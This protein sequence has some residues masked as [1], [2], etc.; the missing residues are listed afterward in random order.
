MNAPARRWP[1]ATWRPVTYAPA[2]RVFS[3]PPLGWILH[4]TV[5]NGS[6]WSG[7]E[8]A[9]MG[10]RRF[11]HL[12]VAKD[13][14]AEQF[15]ELDH[16]SWAQGDGNDLYWSVETE[17]YPEE[18]LSLAQVETLARWHIWCGAD[19]ALANQPGW[20]GIGTHYMGGAAWGGHSCLPLDS[21]DVLTLT[22]WK[23]L[24][25]V[26]LSDRVA[27]WSVDSGTIEFAEPLAITPT[28]VADTVKAHWIEMTADHRVYQRQRLSGAY[29][30]VP[31]S[32][33]KINARI[34]LSGNYDGQGLPVSD[35][36]LRLLVHVQADG[37][38]TKEGE[39]RTGGIEFHY[40][41]D[42]KIERMRGIL[43]R[44]GVTYRVYPQASGSTKFRLKDRAWL[45]E[46]VIRWLPDKRF[47]WEW[48]ELDADQF[49]VFTEELMLADGCESRQIYRSSDEI[50]LDIVQALYHLHDRRA[51]R[52]GHGTGLV[53]T[54]SDAF[55]SRPAHMCFYRNAVEPG[56]ERVEVGCLTTHND[57]L[58]IRQ[59]GKVAI[60]GN[61]PDPQGRE[62][63][64]PRSKQRATILSTAKAIRATGGTD[65]PLT[66]DDLAKVAAAVWGAGWGK[67]VS[68]GV[69]IQRLYATV[70]PLVSHPVPGAPT[71]DVAALAADLAPLIAAA[72]P[73]AGT[74]VD[75]AALAAAVADELAT[76]LV[77]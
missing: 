69:M 20:P 43:D 45:A 38:Y 2:A 53:A 67:S 5:S 46:N 44:L 42:R 59:G 72:L 77:R 27:S 35:D 41:L 76:R 4:V 8:T 1:G 50:N 64:G 28:Y 18:P 75:P 52:D 36:L 31:A 40:G 55:R 24:R 58:M 65:M 22:G 66:T 34:P 57:T 14:R 70:D 74:P 54:V 56:R 23:A 62:G 68:A 73:P 16:D 3:K 51:N 33:L 11:S 63:S 12:W 71:I 10:K 6:P 26:T 37:H 49:D 21:T 47:T 29:K 30:A 13:G 61:C 25:D 39:R 7:F 9:P 60:V 48:L 17:G 19:D 32:D 15:A